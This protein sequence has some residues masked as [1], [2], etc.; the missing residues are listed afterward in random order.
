MPTP[1]F[2]RIEGST[3]GLITAGCSTLA[4]MALCSVVQG[5]TGAAYPLGRYR[6][7]L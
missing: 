2:M 7:Q 6:L 4:R 5:C 1:A 3:Q